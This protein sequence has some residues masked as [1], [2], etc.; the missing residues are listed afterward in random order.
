[1]KVLAING[2]PHQNGVTFTALKLVADELAKEGIS[3]DFVHVGSIPLRGC[4]DCLLCR[5]NGNFRCAIDDMVNQALARLDESDGLLLGAPTYFCGIPGPAKTFLDRFFYASQMT[6]CMHFKAG[7]SVTALRRSGGVTALHQLNNYL[8]PSHF[9]MVPSQYHNGLFGKSPAE[10]LADEEG[11]QTLKMLGR[12]MAWLMH[13]LNYARD[14]Y[15]PPEFEERIRTN[16]PGNRT[17]NYQ[18]GAR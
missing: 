9:I 17:A 15:P 8:M 18:E 12:N 11:V 3:T 13:T 5:R 1:M 10:A 4:T 6:R 2:S 16:F 14:A 7:A